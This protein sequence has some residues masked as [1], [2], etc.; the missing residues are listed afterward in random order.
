[1]TRAAPRR[2]QRSGPDVPRTLLPAT[3]AALA[4]PHSPDVRVE[5]YPHGHTDQA[6]PLELRG[7]DLVSSADSYDRTTCRL[8][9]PIT[10]APT[11]WGSL[12]TPD[13]ARL[14]VTYGV[15]VGDPA[16]ELA[17]LWVERVSVT[18]P[19]G[20]VTVEAGTLAAR[21]SQAGFPS[22]DR[23]YSGLT[24]DVVP[25]I[26]HDALGWTP[27]SRVE[28][29]LTSGG[30]TVTTAQV[31]SGDPWQA[32]ESLLDAAGGEAYFDGEDLVMR[33]QPVT[34]A[35]ADWSFAVGDG[36]TVTGYESTLERAPNVV[37]LA[38]Q[39]PAGT[40]ADVVGTATATGGADP[41]GPY[42]YFRTDE[43]RTGRMSQAQAND[44]ARQ[45]LERVG[46]FARPV[47]LTCVPHPGVMVG[48]TVAVTYAN[49]ATE[50][51]RVIT[52]RFPLTPGD[53]MTLETKALP[54]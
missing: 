40:A 7:G 12:L 20:I 34:K 15:G 8:E 16:A 3:L 9:L 32:I 48:D 5:A 27:P 29:S 10:Y 51:C 18:R 54:W 46:G 22:A 38:V 1:M 47:T 14:R 21:I 13:D 31:F 35:T 42:G 28:G 2:S 26:A 50:R 53:A 45:W 52:V 49:G 30:P 24:T 23:R 39:D 17:R 33:P 6:V 11:G 43:T 41:T 37:R 25:R 19:E 36:G 44:A 4:V